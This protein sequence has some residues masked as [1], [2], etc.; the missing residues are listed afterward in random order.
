MS[1]PETS[2]PETGSANPFED[3]MPHEVARIVFGYGDDLERLGWIT[4]K[5]N[6]PPIFEGSRRRPAGVVM[7]SWSNLRLGEAVAWLH[8][9]KTAG[10]YATTLFHH[11]PRS[12]VVP[13]STSSRRRFERL[14]AY[15]LAERPKPGI[16]IA[17]EFL[18][19]AYKEGMAIFPR[20]TEEKRWAAKQ[21]RRAVRRAAPGI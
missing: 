13:I 10:W 8:D 5:E 18:P 3:V 17:R 21:F 9:L 4:E 19:N 1:T 7:V 11:S 6:D 15:G 2:T 14:L 20:D 16:P 12:R